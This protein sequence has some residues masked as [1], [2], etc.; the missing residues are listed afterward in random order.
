MGRVSRFVDNAERIFETAQSISRAGHDASEMT[1]LIDPDGGIRLVA[2]CD[3]PLDSLLVHHGAQMVY[4]V[5]QQANRVRLE[6]RAGSR[7]CLFEAERPNGVARRL[8]PEQRLYALAG[9][10]PTTGRH[11]A[12]TPPLLPA[13]SD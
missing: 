8:L 1:I 2:G 11:P 10:P 6:G 3:W 4:R 5:G 12:G 9:P 13:A 7:T